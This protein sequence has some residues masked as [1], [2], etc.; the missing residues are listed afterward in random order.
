MTLL[1]GYD[2]DSFFGVPSVI[3]VP[4]HP[5]PMAKHALPAVAASNC[6]FPDPASPASQPLGLGGC[7]HAK[8]PC[9]GILGYLRESLCLSFHTSLSTSRLVAFD[10]IH[11]CAD[12]QSLFQWSLAPRSHT[13]LRSIASPRLLPA[14]SEQFSL[15]QYAEWLHS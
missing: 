3:V 2:C 8:C 10:Q 11:Y 4:C 14:T 7:R 5:G 15:W 6:H 13:C 9:Q 12:A 1:E